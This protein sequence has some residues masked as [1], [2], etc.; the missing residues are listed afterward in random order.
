MGTGRGWDRIGTQWN[1][2]GWDM[3]R[4]SMGQGQNADWIG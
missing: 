3:D 1:G 2:Q 4:D